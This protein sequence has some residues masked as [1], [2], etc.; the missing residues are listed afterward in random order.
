MAASGRP[1]ASPFGQGHDIGLD[2]GVLEPEHLAGA[3]E[4]RLNFVGDE[5]DAVLVA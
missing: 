5:Q 4:A 2:A 1:P 3:G